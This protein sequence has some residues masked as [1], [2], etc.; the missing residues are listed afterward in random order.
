MYTTRL[1]RASSRSSTLSLSHGA[2]LLW[3]EYA[4][5]FEPWAGQP[6]I[7]ALNDEHASVEALLAKAP[8]DVDQPNPWADAGVVVTSK[9]YLVRVLEAYGSQEFGK[10]STTSVVQPILDAAEAIADSLVG[11]TFV[12]GDVKCQRRALEKSLSH[13]GRFDCTRD[14]A[15]VSLIIHVRGCPRAPAPAPEPAKSTRAWRSTP[16]TF[17]GYSFA[18]KHT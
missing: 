11:V 10:T 7:K 13:Q 8:V 15:C 3:Q 18:T 4:T 1:S 14:Y 17:A 5:L 16:L 6:W 9:A 2:P 12:S